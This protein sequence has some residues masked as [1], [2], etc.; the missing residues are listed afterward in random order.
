M[1][2]G[3]CIRDLLESGKTVILPGF[4]AL[5]ITTPEG[6]GSGPG[7]GRMDPPG[8]KVRFDNA[9]TRDDG[10]LAEAFAGSAGLD[11]EEARQQV[12]ELVDAIRFALDKGE[13]G[14]VEGAGTFTR[15]GEGKVRFQPAADWVVEP[16][17][18]GLESMDLLELDEEAAEEVPVPEETGREPA[19][20]VEKVTASPGPVPN[21]PW[22]GAKNHRKTNLWRVIWGVAGLLIVVLLVLIFLPSDTF[23]FSGSGDRTETEETPPVPAGEDQGDANDESP[24][25]PRMEEQVFQEDSDGDEGPATEAVRPEDAPADR[26]FIVAGSF[27]NLA[28]ASNLQDRLLAKGY[29][30]EVMMTENRMYRVTAASFTDEHEAEVALTRIKSEPGME[31]CWLLSNE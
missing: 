20:H 24:E 12:L 13:V 16:D 4:G 9:T 25:T 30:A 11:P 10:L 8:R 5:E 7:S 28:N 15:D 14:L 2:I 3:A 21:E 23:D 1:T 6:M 17:Q 29:E 19:E 26:F 31:S 27:R 22:K 18:Y